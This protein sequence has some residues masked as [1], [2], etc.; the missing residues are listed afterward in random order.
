MKKKRAFVDTE[1]ACDDSDVSDDEE[2]DSELSGGDLASF[3][4]DDEDLF[5]DDD[6]SDGPSAEQ[7]RT[8]LFDDLTEHERHRIGLDAVGCVSVVKPKPK[9]KLI[10]V[11]GDDDEQCIGGEEV[12]VDSDSDSDVVCTGSLYPVGLGAAWIVDAMREREQNQQQG[13]FEFDEKTREGYYEEQKGEEENFAQPQDLHEVC[14]RP[15]QFLGGDSADNPFPHCHGEL[16]DGVCNSDN[17][18]L[19]GAV[20]YNT[21][22]NYMA[23]CTNVLVPYDPSTRLHDSCVGCKAV[24]ASASA[25]LDPSAVAVDQHVQCAVIKSNGSR[26]VHDALTATNICFRC[27]LSLNPPADCPCSDCPDLDSDDDEPV[28]PGT[29]HSGYDTDGHYQSDL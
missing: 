18:H 26:C 16:I 1:A 19:C 27:M 24:A 29:Q 2:T 25:S 23:V 20:Y 14:N 15:L 28:D 12:V 10:V 3:V 21:D 22:Q 4:D 9:P 17:D 6:D 5:V 13:V 7:L 8:Y 11:D